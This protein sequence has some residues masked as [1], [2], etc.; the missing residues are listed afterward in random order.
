MCRRVALWHRRSRAAAQRHP[1]VRV[2]LHRLAR[3]AVPGATRPV[4]RALA[5]LLRRQDRGAAAFAARQRGHGVQSTSALCFVC[6]HSLLYDI[7]RNDKSSTE[8]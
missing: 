8:Q 1:Q 7:L 6:F 3:G 2:A 5:A 4:G